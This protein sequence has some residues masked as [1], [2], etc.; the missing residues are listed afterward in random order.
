MLSPPPL[1][2]IFNLEIRERELLLLLVVKEAMRVP[3]PRR[4]AD[5]HSGRKERVRVG[6]QSMRFVARC[7]VLG[8]LLREGRVLS[9]GSEGEDL[10][11]PF[12]SILA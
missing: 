6:S 3:I 11:D 5:G 12:I 10:L 9:R 1:T 4:G 8:A 2:V 7:G